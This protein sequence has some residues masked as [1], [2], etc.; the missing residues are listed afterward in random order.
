[1]RS[2]A[3]REN[4]HDTFREP[5]QQESLRGHL[6]GPMDGVRYWSVYQGYCSWLDANAATA[7]ISTLGL[8]PVLESV[9]EDPIKMIA[10]A[11]ARHM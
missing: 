2:T 5:T 6:T 9:V 10:Y 4:R 7:E 11:R 3:Q 8:A 1:M